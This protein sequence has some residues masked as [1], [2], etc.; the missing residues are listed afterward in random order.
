[1]KYV[2]LAY[3]FPNKDD[4]HATSLMNQISRIFSIVDIRM[5]TTND[6]VDCRCFSLRMQMDMPKLKY[7]LQ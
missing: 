6:Y 5:E 1:M 7:Q 3:Q 4:Y 2:Q